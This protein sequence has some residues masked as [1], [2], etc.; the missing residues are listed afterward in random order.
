MGGLKAYSM[1]AQTRLELHL[2]QTKE[3][4]KAEMKVDWSSKAWRNAHL[5]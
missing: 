2:E 1:V 3:Y 4:R 5:R